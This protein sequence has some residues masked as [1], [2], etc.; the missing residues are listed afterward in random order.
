M[1]HANHTDT[2]NTTTDEHKLP[3]TPVVTMAPPKQAQRNPKRYS[4][5]VLLS[6]FLGSFGFD[7]F[8]LGYTG[9][10]IAKLLTCGGLGVWAFIDCILILV[11]RLGPADKQ[12]LLD[13]PADKKP[14]VIAVVTV[15]LVN[16]FNMA[17]VG[18]FVGYIGYQLINNPDFFKNMQSSS[19]RTADVNAY[20][21]LTVGMTKAEVEQAF[22]G[23]G[24][25]LQT[26]A[27]HADRLGSFEECTFVRYSLATKSSLIYTTFTEGKLSEKS[28][29]EPREET[30]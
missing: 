16:F 7:R 8:Y 12:E 4:T 30:L 22:E 19:S 13:Y 21:R 2:D 23:S 29:Q 5:A 20:D 17:L 14:M 24:Y 9:L 3:K 26:C 11:G 1:P 18:T 15:Y 27:K 25:T 28:E 6:L 10:G